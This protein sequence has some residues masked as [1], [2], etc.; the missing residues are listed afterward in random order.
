[1]GHGMGMDSEY[2]VVQAAQEEAETEK[3]ELE[4]ALE[5]EMIQQISKSNNDLQSK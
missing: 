3:E 5:G 1:M 2:I 4:Q